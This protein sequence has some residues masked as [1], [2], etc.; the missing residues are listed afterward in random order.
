MPDWYLKAIGPL[1]KKKKKSG[2]ISILVLQWESVLEGFIKS[3]PDLLVLNFSM[4]T[5]ESV[6]I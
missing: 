3:D 6:T 5:T 2:I 4:K 1:Q